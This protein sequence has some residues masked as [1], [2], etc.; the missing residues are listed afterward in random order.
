MKLTKRE[1]ETAAL[2][3]RQNEII[4]DIAQQ[5]LISEDELRERAAKMLVEEAKLAR[6]KEQWTP[7]SPG[8]V[9]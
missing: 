6:E 2:I 3:D 8:S 7:L 1:M 9:H 4:R 5:F